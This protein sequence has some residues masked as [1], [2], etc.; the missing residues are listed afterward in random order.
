MRSELDVGALVSIGDEWREMGEMTLRGLELGADHA[1]A[2]VGAPRLRIVRRDSAEATDGAGAVAAFQALAEEG[3]RVFV[4]PQGSPG[5][6]ALLPVLAEHPDVLM[7]TAS[8]GVADLHLAGPMLFNAMGVHD[9]C[10]RVVA[11]YARDR[12]IG[13]VAIVAST[14]AWERRQADAFAHAFGALGGRVVERCDPPAA[15][16][17]VEPAVERAL[18]GGPDALFLGC[19]N[20]I[21]PAA[22]HVAGLGYRGALLAAFVDEPGLQAGGAALAGLVF[23]RLTDPSPE[24]RRRFVE[25][26]GVQPGWPAD[27]AYDA[28]LAIMHAAARAGSTDAATIAEALR[29][30]DVQGAAGRMRFDADGCAM[31]RPAL[32][33]VDDARRASRL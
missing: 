11:A 14:H 20:R 18:A 2:L 28:A 1:L 16:H 23:A 5:I 31:R 24:F 32:W 27:H 26:F 7:M 3:L 13:R 19:F 15:S 6:R 9:E 17:D 8:A 22:R 4:G 25:R 10:A 30:V 33:R 12:G 21:G 29:S